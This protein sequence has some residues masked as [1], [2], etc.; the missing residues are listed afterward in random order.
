MYDFVTLTERESN[1]K[2]GFHTLANIFKLLKF[3]YSSNFFTYFKCFHTFH[4]FHQALTLFTLVYL[5][6]PLFTFVQMTHKFCP[7][8]NLFQQRSS[9]V[10]QTWEIRLLLELLLEG[11]CTVSTVVLSYSAIT[12]VQHLYNHCA[13]L[14]QLFFHTCTPAVVHLLHN[15]FATVIHLL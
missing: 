7:C 9:A 11:R 5:C 3:L 10:A 14:A 12:V 6:I 1:F 8:F 13:T 2:K 15:C 4:N